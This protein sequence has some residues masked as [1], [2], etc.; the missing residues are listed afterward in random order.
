M[1]S[2]RTSWWLTGQLG[3]EDFTQQ[4]LRI[5]LKPHTSLPLGLSPTQGHSSS[6]ALQHHG[7]KPRPWAPS[8]AQKSLKAVP[9]AVTSRQLHATK[10]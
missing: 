4:E 6:K 5:C 2:S 1:S 8:L 3:V 7:P 10:L 9:R